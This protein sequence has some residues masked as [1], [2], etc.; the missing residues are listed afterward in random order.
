M[1]RWWR[2]VRGGVGLEHFGSDPVEGVFKCFKFLPLSSGNWTAEKRDLDMRWEMPGTQ[3]PAQKHLTPTS[4][5]LN[6]QVLG[7]AG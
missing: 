5:T 6:Q 4:I 3:V 1:T 2:E 7:A